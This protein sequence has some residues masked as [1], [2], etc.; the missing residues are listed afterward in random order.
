M[1]QDF[2]HQNWIKVGSKHIN[3]TC[4]DRNPNTLSLIQV[5]LPSSKWSWHEDLTHQ[6]NWMHATSPSTEYVRSWYCTSTYFNLK[7]WQ[8]L[9]TLQGSPTYTVENE[10]IDVFP[11]EPTV[12]ISSAKL[13]NSEALML[14]KGQE[15]NLSEIVQSPKCL[16][17]PR[18]LCDRSRNAPA[19]LFLNKLEGNWL[20]FFRERKIPLKLQ[21]MKRWAYFETITRH[22]NILWLLLER[23]GYCPHRKQSS[24]RI[25]LDNLKQNLHLCFWKGKI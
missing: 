3:C 1:L 2:F 16:C 17:V 5:Y 6:T 15:P 22:C 11:L 14:P 4:G 8:H 21:E 10:W 12:D 7:S 18:L 9:V 23:S 20:F 25:A 24:W 19:I 13:N